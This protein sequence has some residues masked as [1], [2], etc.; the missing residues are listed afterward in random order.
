MEWGINEVINLLILII[1]LVCIPLM[2]AR[3]NRRQ[4]ENELLHK[5]IKEKDQENKTYKEKIEEKLYDLNS[6]MGE[7][8]LDVSKENNELQ[9]KISD[10]KSQLKDKLHE[11]ELSLMDL[12]SGATNEQTKKRQRRGAIN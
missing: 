12:N 5:R 2:L 4:K 3:E 7:L 6:Q 9:A 8:Q 10:F 11:L 1:G